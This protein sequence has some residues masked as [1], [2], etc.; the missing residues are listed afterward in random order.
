MGYPEKCMNFLVYPE[1][2]SPTGESDVSSTASLLERALNCIRQ[3]LSAEGTAFLTLAREQLLP[4]QLQL[5]AVIE[6][7]SHASA[8]HAHAQQALHEASKRFAESDNRQQV[9][10]EALKKLLP[11]L[12]EATLPAHSTGTQ[13]RKNTGEN[14]SLRLLQP[15]ESTTELSE[16]H[17]PSSPENR[18]TLPP[19]YITCF[20]RFEVRRSDPSSSPISLCNNLKG[21][22]I[23]RYLISQPKH[24]ETVDMLMAALWPEEVSEVAD[25]KLRVAISALR[26]SLNRNFVS[27][28][29]GGYILC[30]D[31]GYQLNP[32]VTIQS[33]VDEF[34]ALYQAGLKASDR[35][36][37]TLYYEQASQLY[38]GPF[39]AEDLYAEWSFIQRE[40]LSKTYVVMCDSLAE[41]KLETGRYD[42]AA[43]WASA[44]LKM[45]RCDEEAH[46]QLIRAYAAEGRRS[47]ALRQYHYCERVLSEELG[48]QPAPETQKLF[49]K[50]MIGE[51]SPTLKRN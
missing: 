46:R 21:Q 6:S 28:P 23:L 48:V 17:Q 9:Q 31:H 44:I 40:E 51:D 20:S 47:G 16:G 14:Q 33:D 35:K 32:S 39:L 30:K 41:F 49:Q 2:H 4:N 27:E 18:N 29:G 11:T 36:T 5:I 45:D 19:L 26:C 7:L 24:R 3:G 8:T 37:A 50:L 43:K 38:S 34:L 10:I 1:Q 25:H 22:A 15:P 12:V 42:A 13:L